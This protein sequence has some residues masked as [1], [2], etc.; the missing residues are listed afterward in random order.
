MPRATPLSVSEK[1]QNRLFEQMGMLLT[2]THQT[3]ALLRAAL[4]HAGGAA[5]GFRA[6]DDGDR[7]TMGALIRELQRK[8][9]LHPYFAEDL[10]SLL[11][12]RN[13][14]IH[15]LTLKSWFDFDQAHG[16]NRALV[17]MCHYQQRLYDVTTV[18]Y[19]YT[20]ALPAHEIDDDL[21]EVLQTNAYPSVR[22]II[23]RTNET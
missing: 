9:Q 18:L 1:Q 22:E 11:Q 12:Q 15:H 17:W 10:Q 19:A 23:T 4:R 3:E 16:L 13:E 21:R 2:V 5:D 7:R 14:F 8:V 20:D 6:L